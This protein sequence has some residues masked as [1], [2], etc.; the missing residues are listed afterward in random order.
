M[1]HPRGFVS[2]VRWLTGDNHVGP[3]GMKHLAEALKI[4]QTV[5]SVTIGGE[6]CFLLLCFPCMLYECFVSF[7]W[8]CFVGVVVNRLQP[9]RP[10]GD[11]GPGG[12]AEDQPDGDLS[13]YR[14]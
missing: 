7:P 14:R 1:F 12:G 4:N 2:L 11:E 5:T 9:R 13:D 10:R 8:F 6:L 3:E